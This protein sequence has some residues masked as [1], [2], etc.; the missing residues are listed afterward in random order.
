[1]SFSGATSEQRK[2]GRTVILFKTGVG[3]ARETGQQDNGYVIQ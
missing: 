1:M 3:R 2:W